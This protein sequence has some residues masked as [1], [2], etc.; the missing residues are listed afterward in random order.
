MTTTI[1]TINA[2]QEI[3]VP[4]PGTLL[5]QPLTVEE[6]VSAAIKA[7][8]AGKP[9]GLMLFQASKPAQTRIMQIVNSRQQHWLPGRLNIRPER[10]WV[11]NDVSDHDKGG[12]E[13]PPVI[14]RQA[15][16]YDRD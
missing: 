1:T 13:W 11:W 7:H 2:I 16:E 4:P 12:Y 9:F 14:R 15:D 8:E 10:G 3:P 5:S 6:E